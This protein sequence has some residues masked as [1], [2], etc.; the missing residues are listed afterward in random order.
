MHSLKKEIVF[1]SSIIPMAGDKN[2]ASVL[3]YTALGII[4][5]TILEKNESDLTLNLLA[6][7]YH[8]IT[9]RYKEEFGIEERQHLEGDDGFLMLKDVEITMTNGNT[10]ETNFFVLFY[11]QIIGVSLSGD[12]D[13]SEASHGEVLATGET[14]ETG[15]V[16]ETNKV[17]ETGEIQE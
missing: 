1:K 12:I 3:F 9:K 8:D 13:V 6:K 15:K 10:R 2:A 4:N 7:T 17:L 16:S 11:D 14:L 5:G